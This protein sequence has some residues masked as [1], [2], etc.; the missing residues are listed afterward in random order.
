MS[1]KEWYAQAVRGD[2]NFDVP[3]ILIKNEDHYKM[4]INQL[5][6]LGF[7]AGNDF[8]NYGVPVTVV[9]IWYCDFW[10][11]H[12]VQVDKFKTRGGDFEF[13][14]EELVALDKRGDL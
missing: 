1:F 7:G 6:R 9:D 12:I 2:D 8:S 14:L 5:E 10:N 4:V 11:S 3:Y 13:K